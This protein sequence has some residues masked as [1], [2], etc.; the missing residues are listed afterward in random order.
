MQEDD[1]ITKRISADSSTTKSFIMTMTTATKWTQQSWVKSL[2][3]TS[4]SQSQNAC[5]QEEKH[6]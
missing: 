4:Q 5:G 6:L 1:A 2:P 3:T